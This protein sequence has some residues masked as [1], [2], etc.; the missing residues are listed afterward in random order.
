MNLESLA[1]SKTTESGS[2][3]HQEENKETTFSTRGETNCISL[4]VTFPNVL[5]N[6]SRRNTRLVSQY[7]EPVL[8]QDL[9]LAYKDNVIARKPKFFDIHLQYLRLLHHHDFTLEILLGIKLETMY[10]HYEINEKILNNL[11]QDIGANRKTRNNL[12]QQFLRIS[13]DK[14]DELRFDKTILK[15]TK[16]MLELKEKYLSAL[17]NNKKLIH[18]I[19][20]LWTDIET[21]RSKTGH[22]TAPQSLDILKKDMNEDEFNERW[23][24][25]FE[26]EYSDM[27]IKIEY[28]YVCEYLQYKELKSSKERKDVV[29]PKLQFDSDKIK[30]LVNS[31]VSDIINKQNIEMKL[32]TNGKCW[33]KLT[34]HNKKR[35][36]FLKVYVDNVFVCES[37]KYSSTKNAYTIHLADSISIEILNTNKLVKIV[38]Y[39][40]EVEISY[41]KVHLNQIK[42]SIA[43][44]NFTIK[45][46]VYEKLTVPTSKHVGSGYDMKTI[47]HANNIRLTSSN[48][49]K[50]KLFTTFELSIKVGW[51]EKTT[52]NEEQVKYFIDL[53]SSISNLLLGKQPT[54]ELLLDL[55]SRVYEKNVANY[56][57]MLDALKGP[58]KG[59][60]KTDEDTGEKDENL[61]TRLR[62]LHLRN[63]GK[64]VELQN[65]RV[66]LVDSQ[67]STH[68]LS[69]LS[70]KNMNKKND[71]EDK[72]LNSIDLHRYLSAKYVMKLNNN[73]LAKIDEFLLQ[74]TYRDVVRDFDY[75]N[76]R[77][78]FSVG[79]SLNLS[80]TSALTRQQVLRDCLKDEQEIQ[81]TVVRAYNLYDRV[82]ILDIED[83]QSNEDIA[84]FK[85]RSLR[86]FLR[87][88]Y[89]GESHQTPTAVGCHPTWNHT[90]VIKS[91]LEPLSCI[92]INIYDEYRT[93]IVD[94]TSEQSFHQRRYTLWL[95][96]VQI[97]L[98]SIL[99]AGSMNGAFK[100]S[101]TPFMFGYEP[102]KENK[103]S[104]DVMQLLRTD[105]AL[106][107]LNIT[108]N[109]SHL[110]AQSYSEPI[111]NND[112]DDLIIKQINAFT[113]DYL[114][115][116]SSRHISL[117]FVDSSGCNRCITEFLQPLPVPDD[118]Y[119]PKDPKRNESGMSKGSAY[120]KSS[121]SKSSR[122]KSI[123][124][125]DVSPFS[126]A[127]SWTKVETQP[128]NIMD[129]VIRYVS[130]IPTY[131]V[132]EAY[133]VTLTGVELLKVLNGSPLDHTLLLASFFIF[134]GI[135]CYVV[136][137][138]GLP[139]GVSSYVLVKFHQNQVVTVDNE[140]KKGYFAKTEGSSWYVYDA[141]SG[142]RYDIREIGCPLKTVSHVFDCENIWV[143]VQSSQEC[144]KIS[145][146]L[147]KTS[148][149]QPVFNKPL[150]V[151]R[152]MIETLYNPPNEVE[153]LRIALE[154]KI[155]NKIQK[156]RSQ[157]KTVWNRYCSGLL[158]ETLPQWEYWAFNSANPRPNPDHR[159]KQLMVTYKICGFPLNMP[160]ANAKQITSRVKSTAIHVNDDPN[161]EF[162]LAVE[163]FP[164]PNN[165][166]SV[167]VYLA[168]IV[169]IND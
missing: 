61:S 62:L 169:K 122:K 53:R 167:W 155:K 97:P 16:I 48:L 43:H 56:V 89:H 83:N 58:C 65:E 78:I 129:A 119:F 71:Y 101:T 108:T 49:F 45:N 76:I 46:F 59:K 136:I 139:R 104:A 81:I 135:K 117:T 107:L 37:E 156:W 168:S 31:M 87:V 1:Y 60:A 161:M 6:V 166:L 42:E 33:K 17:K 124:G 102:S 73:L 34:E 105:T 44:A 11:Q 164:Y 111:V 112:K 41:V 51:N 144:G 88:S 79:L 147:T 57:K 106:I 90:V 162:G 18:Y 63:T 141:V 125:D 157:T 100:I 82:A 146:D 24:E 123:D 113:S 132:L 152:P 163:V 151:I 21:L 118:S 15:Y 138:W 149:W 109:I 75:L 128:R 7:T 3:E 114:N 127:G 64:L 103:S 23:I 12:R 94:P 32:R 154:S 9:A 120:S 55:V 25:I 35:Q 8:F 2:K 30:K 84:G 145:M 28:E 165:V 68:Q 133:V 150:F 134:L 91:K 86:P 10:E 140:V 39:E 110:A 72:E 50:G 95:G 40:N 93:S 77:N 98:R 22:I 20:L 36:Y 92:N 121:S 137:G 5:E 148:D 142:Q 131:E 27:L 38:L 74:K 14:K 19:T 80:P 99:E 13:P 70:N 54:V 29:K 47:A 96:T 85:M 130:L 126:R 143:N 153:E 159:L 115:N 4:D 67:I 52:S 160:Y 66:P 116:F 26:Q 158:R 69:A